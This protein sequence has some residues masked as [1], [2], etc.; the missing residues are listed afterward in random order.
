MGVELLD[1]RVAEC[2][3]LWLAEGDNKTRMEITF[4]NNCWPLIDHFFKTIKKI[5]NI[6][7]FRFR[8]YTYTPNGSKVQIPIKGI[9]KRYYLHKRATKPYFILRL[10]SVE[11]VKEWKKIVRD[12]LANKDFSPYVLR[13]FFAGEGNIHSGAHNNRVLRIAQ[14][15]RKKY[16]EDLLNQIGITKY[17]FYAPKR[18]YLIWNKKN[19]DIFAKLKIADLHPDKKERFWRLY[20]SFKEEHYSPNYLIEEVYKNLN[21][22]KTTRELAKIYKRSFARLQD[23]VILLKKQGRISNFQIG[24]VSYW[25][26]DENELI[27][28]KIKK[29]YL[30]FSKSPRLTFEFSK[31]FK[32]DWQS[33]NRRLKELEKLELVRRRE[34]KKWIK[35]QA[36]K[37]ITVIG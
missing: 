13:G 30:E 16:I 5:F 4:T 9:R 10:A 19:W 2:V 21:S 18:Y 25:T 14:G 35:T 11:I 20:S 17:S 27:I 29:K 8:I 1:R 15:I 36:K 32:V 12:T 26:K 33:S 37:K 22:P 24:S 3:G 7:N 23:V 28:S 31:K 6:E 34:D